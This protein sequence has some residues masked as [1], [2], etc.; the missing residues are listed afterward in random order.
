MTV[1]RHEF[2]MEEALRPRDAAQDGRLQYVIASLGGGFSPEGWL[3]YGQ[4]PVW[5]VVTLLG[6]GVG[7]V[8]LYAREQ[9]V[10]ALITTRCSTWLGLFV[11]WC[12][13]AKSRCHTTRFS[14]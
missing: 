6:P 2:G 9:S 7:A 1:F 10:H 5:T 12:E 8:N 4:H 3:V 14:Q 11:R 13:L